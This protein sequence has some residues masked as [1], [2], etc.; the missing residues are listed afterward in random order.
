M[1][2][3]IVV[4]QD[5]SNFFQA[6]IDVLNIEIDYT[7]PIDTPKSPGVVDPGLDLTGKIPTITRFIDPLKRSV[8]IAGKEATLAWTIEPDVVD[9]VVLQGNESY[10]NPPTTTFNPDDWI[11]R[12]GWVGFLSNIDEAVK[13]YDGSTVYYERV[14]G[15]TTTGELLGLLFPNMPAGLDDE[16]VVL[17]VDVVVRARAV[18]VGSGSVTGAT[19]FAWLVIGGNRKGLVSQPIT[20]T[21]TDFRLSNAGWDQDWTQQQLNG[22]LVQFE[23]AYG[24]SSSGN[25]VRLHIDAVDLEIKWSPQS[26]LQISPDEITLDLDGQE[27][28][29]I[30]SQIK[31]PGVV[32]PGLDLT[33]ESPTLGREDTVYPDPEY[34][35]FGEKTPGLL[36]NSVNKPDKDPLILDEKVPNSV[37]N[38][39]TKPGIDELDLT[40]KVPVSDWVD[41]HWQQPEGYF[42]NIFEQYPAPESTDNRTRNP[43]RIIRYLNGKTP[44]LDWEDNHWVDP[45]KIELPLN[46]KTPNLVPGLV[47]APPTYP[48]S[49]AG[50]VPAV[51]RGEVKRPGVVVSFALSGQVPIAWTGPYRVRLTLSM[52]A[53][54]VGEGFIPSADTL[55]LASTEFPADVNDVRFILEGP[56]SLAL[57]G[58]APSTDVSS[59]L[60][61]ASDSRFISLSIDYNIEHIGMAYLNIT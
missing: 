42:L 21:Y 20:E 25:P 12:P 47:K 27:P 3:E 41:N 49:L 35:Q 48:V 55:T 26:P 40:G 7:P 51:L 4:D 32:D 39:V 23:F 43:A 59:Q 11:T 6:L 19:L 1:E 31:S 14:S 46:E 33:G 52:Q 13:D 45:L 29:A 36:E 50:K 44:V 56:G 18:V 5:A 34:L 10:V 54:F 28:E 37:V 22:L 58:S 8:S 38:H 2:V 16:A 17:S 57:T 30:P 24:A 53:P 61:R 15:T 60:D 9:S